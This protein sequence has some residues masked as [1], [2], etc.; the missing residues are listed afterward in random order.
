MPD[1]TVK[2]K[3]VVDPGKV[4]SM[5]NSKTE[6]Y[7]CLRCDTKQIEAKI[8]KFRAPTTR[9][10]CRHCGGTVYPVSG[11]GDKAVKVRNCKDCGTRLRATNTG[12]YCSVHGGR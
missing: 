11:A 7:E 2:P 1:E 6:Q 12:T 3:L 10:R 8:P 4:K 5:G 9:I